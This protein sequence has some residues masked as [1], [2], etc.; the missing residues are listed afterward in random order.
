[1]ITGVEWLPEFVFLG[2]KAG[3]RFATSAE[4]A[5][6]KARPRRTAA[7]VGGVVVAKDSLVSGVWAPGRVRW[8]RSLWWLLVEWGG[9]F[10]GVYEGILSGCRFGNRGFC[11]RI[12][13]VT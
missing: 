3:A 13:G 2:G 8:S 7:L 5:P 9:G 11:G 12:T 4:A 1:M 6:R 10:L